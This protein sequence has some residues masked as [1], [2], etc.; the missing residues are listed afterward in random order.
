MTD[1]WKD[2]D[3]TRYAKLMHGLQSGVAMMQNYDGGVASGETSPKKLRTDLG[4]T[5]AET[6]ALISLLIDKG[7]F[8]TLEFEARLFEMLEGEI[9]KYERSLTAK[10]NGSAKDGVKLL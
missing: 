9:K 1:P 4:S 5:S 7:V 10:A 6:S 2:F 8:T 3:F